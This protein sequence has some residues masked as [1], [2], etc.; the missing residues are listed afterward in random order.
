MTSP[1]P[2]RE[3]AWLLEEYKLLSAHYF[4]ED[5]IYFR[6]GGLLITLNSALIAVSAASGEV[7]RL[8]PAVLVLFAFFGFVVTLGWM[9]MLWRIRAVRQISSKR[10][11][12]IEAG[13]EA[14][15]SA[16]IASPR[17]RLRMRERLVAEAGRLPSKRV[18]G[19]PATV[20]FLLVPVVAAAYWVCLPFWR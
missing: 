11:E 9:A 13:L 20:L 6:T 8:P 16:A 14:S 19:V 12:E 5:Q 7:S 4:H 2:E 1:L 17:I 15:W 3:E 18:T 10:I